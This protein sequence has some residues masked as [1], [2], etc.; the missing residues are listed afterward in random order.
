LLSTERVRDA[1]VL[2]LLQQAE[3]APGLEDGQRE[4]RCQDDEQAA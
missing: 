4:W 3:D 1:A 2:A